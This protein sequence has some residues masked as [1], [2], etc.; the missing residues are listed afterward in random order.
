MNTSQC[1]CLLL[2]LA[3]SLP[4]QEV[5]KTAFWK[6]VLRATPAPEMPILA[7]KWVK[8]TAV[9]ERA[10]VTAGVVEAAVEINP[11]SATLVVGAISRA[12]PEMAAVAAAAAAAKQP[13]QADAICRAATTVAPAMAA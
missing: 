4:A 6:K 7:A 5:A 10:T 2:F 3:C 1:I 8:E 13:A 12:M 11:A 9:S